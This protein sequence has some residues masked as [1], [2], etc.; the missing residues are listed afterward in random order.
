M[1]DKKNSIFS[2]LSQTIKK[3]LRARVRCWLWSRTTSCNF[4]N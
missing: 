1:K 3:M 4:R 2:R